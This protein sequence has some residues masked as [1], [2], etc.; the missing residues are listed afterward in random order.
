MIHATLKKV[1][2]AQIYGTNF[3]RILTE[4]FDL[5]LVT[6]SKAIL[7]Q[8]PYLGAG[9]KGVW[10]K[11]ASTVYRSFGPNKYKHCDAGFMPHGTLLELALN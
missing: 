9:T 7:S 2:N 3:F 4:F 6:S 5:F 10:V 8:N 1:L 11:R